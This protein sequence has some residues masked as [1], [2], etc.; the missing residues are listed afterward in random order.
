[1]DRVPTSLVEIASHVLVLNGSVVI[2][3]VVLPARIYGA[4]AHNDFMTGDVEANPG[5]S[6]AIIQSFIAAA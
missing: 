1:V 2:E 3:M 6:E 5:I 4:P